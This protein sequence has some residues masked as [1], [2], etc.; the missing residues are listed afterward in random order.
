MKPLIFF[1][2]EQQLQSKDRIHSFHLYFPKVKVSWTNFITT[3]QLLCQLL[4]VCQIL[5]GESKAY[6]FLSHVLALNIFLWIAMQNKAY[7]V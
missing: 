1:P 5:H 4:A 2:V 3:S 7:R 6:V